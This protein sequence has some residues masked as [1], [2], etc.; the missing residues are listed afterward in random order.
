MERDNFKTLSGLSAM[1][2]Q[3][4]IQAKAR[5]ASIPDCA[6][7][8]FSKEELEQHALEREERHLK[9]IE[10]SHRVWLQE[11]RE[12]RVRELLQRSAIP[13]LY[14]G[15]TFESVEKR[16][17]SIELAL[18]KAEQYV[19]HWNE[20]GPKGYGFL[21]HG[22]SGLG[23]T[24]LACALLQELQKRHEVQGLY[25]TTYELIADQKKRFDKARR[26]NDTQDGNT[27]ME[28]CLEADFLILDEVG[29]ERGTEFELDLI[30]TLLI[31]RF[32]HLKPTVMVSNLSFKTKNSRGKTLGVYLGQRITDRL[33]QFC[34]MFEFE[35]DSRR[36]EEDGF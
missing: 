11:S 18:Q 33:R 12:R 15:K 36:G 20:Y 1:F 9:E 30:Q 7:K 31:R 10:E 26:E 35:G 22:A 25:V 17:E 21:F 5:G 28:L 13:P 23:K 4:V 16:N 2:R 6:L 32:D 29:L 3:A 24:H 27:L 14:I 8:S 19:G 34:R